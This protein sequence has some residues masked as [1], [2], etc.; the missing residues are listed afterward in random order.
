LDNLRRLLA[1]ARE[2]D[3]GGGDVTAALLP[4]DVQAR[5]D[6]VA[7]EEMIVCG[8][9]FLP[10][11]AEAYDARIRTEILLDEGRLAPPGAVLA[12]WTGPACP[13]L[14][15]ERVALNFFQRLSGVATVTARYVRQVAGTRAAIYD[16]RKTTPGWRTLEKYA[17]RCGGG[18]NHRT[19]LYDAILVK[20]NHLAVL[21]SAGEADPIEA[22]RPRLEQAR[23]RL[24][25][26]GFVQLEVDTLDQLAT[27][28]RMPVDMILLD[29]MTPDQLRQAA[30]M[31]DQ[32]GLA[33]RVELE[34]SGGV[35][36][37][38]LPAIAA[39]GVERIS[40]GALTHSARAVDIGLDIDLESGA[41]GPR[42]G[43]PA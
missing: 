9:A 30:A 42:K 43:G 34:A 5:G 8:G 10:V 21:R 12:R 40:V 33:G 7:R 16:T 2:E 31:R 29:N 37:A 32:A 1:L 17:V 36:L 25:P 24:G 3:L 20:D 22:L 11:I 19:G 13:I 35:T 38:K 14:S 6:F 27:A 23:T 26:G 18:R 15:A 4:Q 39:S 28:L 41:S